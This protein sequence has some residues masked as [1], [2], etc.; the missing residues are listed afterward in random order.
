MT[1]NRIIILTLIITAL[2][3]SY[4]FGFSNELVNF[5]L[6]SGLLA[7]EAVEFIKLRMVVLNSP[8]I[9]QI[10]STEWI[11]GTGVTFFLIYSFSDDPMNGWNISAIIEIVIFGALY[12]LRNRRQVYLI[13]EAGIRN[14]CNHKLLDSSIITGIK[15]DDKTLVIDTTRYSNDIVIRSDVL[16]S[17][18]WD[19]LTSE[20]S[21]LNKNAG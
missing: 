12:L 2:V 4:A 7:F 6:A 8:S 11:Y 15:F 19:E 1:Q 14:L 18:T 9:F 17:P 21:K 20:L 16:Y 3:T 13:E 10:W 5:C